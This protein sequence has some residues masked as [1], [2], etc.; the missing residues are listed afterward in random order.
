MQ[1]VPG[2][3]GTF[4]RLAVWLLLGSLLPAGCSPGRGYEAALLLADIAAGDEPSALKRRTPAPQRRPVAFAM[5]GKHYRGDLYRPV[6]G[7]R[8]GLLLIPGAAEEGRDDPRLV[9]FANS[10][11]RAGFA[12]LVP[13][14]S[15]LRR[16]QVG[17]E[18]ISEVA[19][20]F[21]WLADDAELAPGGRAGMAAFSYAA[22][23]A[24][25]AALRDPIRERVRF[26]F[27]LGGY[28]DLEQTLTFII[29]GCY[30]HEG[31]WRYLEPL[32]YGKWAFVA[33]N[34][35][36][37]KD[38]EDRRLFDTMARRKR[39]DPAASVADLA[40]RLGEEGQALFAL[41][42]NRDPLRV[43]ALLEA[44]PQTIRQDISALNPAEKDLSRLQAQLIL[45][46][47][48][49]DPM[50]PFT[51]SLALA[52]AAPAGQTKLYLAHGL[53]HVDVAPGLPDR[54]RLWQAVRAL[55][56]ARDGK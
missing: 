19:D 32:D 54:W 53:V 16:L 41:I 18:N 51:Q 31:Q 4:L 36:R 40:A 25:L 24:L 8:A 23:P 39:T 37:L 14:L 6:E 38:A 44:L 42:T 46:H 49:E 15:G 56:A 5:E 27:V 7:I 43:P 21:R 55:L 1:R 20:A 33:S 11:A 48:F 30:R 12:V 2:R 29:T 3:Q 13:E 35:H 50:I 9:A 22:G 28:Y 45:V 34:I 10:L 26:I 47:G 17:P 52:E